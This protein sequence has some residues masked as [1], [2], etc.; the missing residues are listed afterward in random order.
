MLPFLS[1]PNSLME[2]ANT[3]GRITFYCLPGGNAQDSEEL[4]IKSFLIMFKK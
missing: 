4:Y 2:E 1:S 3:V